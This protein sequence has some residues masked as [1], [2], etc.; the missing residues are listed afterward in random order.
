MA[1]AIKIPKV[2]KGN[3]FPKGIPKTKAAS[4][5]VQPPVKGKGMATNVTNAKA[6]HLSNLLLCFFLVRLKSQEKKRLNT[7]KCLDKKEEKGSSSH[8]IKATAKLLPI[9][10]QIKEEKIDK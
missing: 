9:V 4:A 3:A 1:P 7:L 5:P 6:P 2:I 10:D 8:K